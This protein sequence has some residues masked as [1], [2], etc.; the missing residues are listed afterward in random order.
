MNPRVWRIDIGWPMQRNKLV[1]KL[2]DGRDRCQARVFAGGDTRPQ[3]T[4][5]AAVGARCEQH[6]AQWE[7]RVAPPAPTQEKDG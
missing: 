6:H 2:A 7:R 3:C 1:P 5:A 4:R